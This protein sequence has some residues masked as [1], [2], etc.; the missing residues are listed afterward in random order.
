ME[1][2]EGRSPGIE[3]PGLCGSR[4]G[5]YRGGVGLIPGALFLSLKGLFAMKVG[6]GAGV[7]RMP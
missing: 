2:R 3:G 6:F 4:Q 1:A 5:R 7:G